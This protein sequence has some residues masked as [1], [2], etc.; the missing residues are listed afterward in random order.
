MHAGEKLVLPMPA[1]PPSRQTLLAT[2]SSTGCAAAN[3][4]SG[5]AA[6]TVIVPCRA[7]TAPP[8]TGASSISSPIAASLADSVRAYSGATVVQHSTT[9]PGASSPAQPFAPNSTSSVCAAFTTNTT[10]ACTSVGRS[11]G[12]S[13]ALPPSA[14]NAART[15][16]RGSQ[17]NTVCSARSK[18]SAAPM[19]IEP[20][21]ITA[22]FISR[23][24]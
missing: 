3:A 18:L 19:P 17:P 4:A 6:I 7:P 13:T 22:T 20:K 8:E 12:R 5:P 21:P 23:C 24:P 2:A 16:S 11:A 9:V 10:T 1:A 14:A 15:A